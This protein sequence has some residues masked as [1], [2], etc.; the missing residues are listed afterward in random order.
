[1]T[2]PKDSDVR[3]LAG[4]LARLSNK[5]SSVYRMSWWNEKLLGWSLAHPEFKSQL[6]RLV[7]VFP[8]TS[9]N[10]D[11]MRHVEEYLGGEGVPA[12]L[13]AAIEV[14]GHVPF[15]AS[16]TAAQTRQNIARMADQFILG[17]STAEAVAGAEKLWNAG[18]GTT[19][20]L[21]GEKT[22]AESEADTYARRVTELLDALT[23][24]APTWATRPVFDA[25]DLGPLP[26][27][28]I[29]IKPT[30][31]AS[32]YKPLTGE[33]GLEQAKGRIRPIL[34]TAR[35]RNALVWFDMEHYEVKDLSIALFRQLL[36]EP[37]FAEL[38][39]GIV[40]QAYLRDSY[41]DLA[42]IVTWSA[43][44]ATPAFVR[45]VKGAYWDTETINA[46]AHD[47]PVPVFQQKP[48]SDANY[49]RCTRLLLDHH[50]EVR[51][52]F[53]SHN[54]RSLAYAISYAR[55]NGLP[56]NAF[57]IQMLYG[58]AEPMHEAIRRSGLRLR[59]YAP[60]GELV[61]GMAYLVRRL[62]E[63]TSNDSFVRLRFAEGRELDELLAVPKVDH[64]P[65]PAPPASRRPTDPVDPTPY[66]PES[67]F[68]WHRRS[69][70]EEM[71]KAVASA[72][73]GNPSYVFAVIDG[74][75]VRTLHSIDSVNPALPSKVVATSARCTAEH[76]RNAMDG[77]RAA[78][79][80]WSATPALQRATVMFRA[81][82]WMRKRRFELAALQ[83][84][85][86]GKPWADAD[87][88]VCEA[89]DFCEYY[90]REALRLSAGGAVQSP[91]GETNKLVYQPRGV[92]VVIAPWN[93]PLAIPTG[94]VVAALVTGNTVL[95]KPAEQ[96]PAIA[97]KL[98]EALHASGL[99][100]GALQFLPGVG[101]EIGPLLVEHP[102]TAFV[103][104]TGSKPVGLSIV[105]SAARHQPCQRH[106]K[107]VIAELGGK[108]PMIVDTDADLD[109]A[110]PAILY[111]AFGF[112]GQKCSALSRLIVLEGV[113]DQLVERLVGA[114][115]GMTVGDPSRMDVEVG[116]VIDA[117]AHERISRVV[118][119][120]PRWGTVRT[121][122]RSLPPVGYF[123]TPTIVA[124]VQP[125][126]PLARDEIFGPVLS[127]FRARHLDEAL[128]LANDTDYALTAGLFSRSPST[129]TRVGAEIRAGN[130]YVNRQITGA[131]VGRQPFGGYGMSGG[132]TKAGGPDYL[133][134]FVE[135][136]VVTENIVRQGF[137]DL[138]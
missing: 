35:D 21:L 11:V 104:F 47:W 50:G 124:D 38:G 83:V 137:A 26:R 101:E 59:V 132:G 45:L 14:A 116:P 102:D 16:V 71:R 115:A 3:E 87:G 43:R 4:E 107:R 29:S 51:P 31:L 20:D 6:F 95:F 33:E 23:A 88:D 32:K 24:A 77:A 56:D 96:T 75:K 69:R 10:R 99:P 61:P 28:S 86:A 74:E 54:M 7:D 63:N 73:A 57:E 52:A 112:A 103:A 60:V 134:N 135:P 128:R 48:Q 91:P 55:A 92:G 113:H 46:N 85:V 12:A 138:A 27:A 111:S 72:K 13:R 2:T 5:K 22:V 44:R 79:P 76:V 30:A 66:E 53:A 25:D 17:S 80:A 18:S 123:I 133:L 119:D 121:A 126:S 37:E 49:E 70:R 67:L 105:E 118:G 98:V 117:E 58:M 39:A 64:L 9:G 130:V 19:I 120:A 40:M 100:K 125:D 82:D 114:V 41:H 81:A 93:F 131:V 108:N 127:V 90:G 62:L 97:S 65:D 15:G 34:R 78:F 136:R 42:D 84:E 89:I 129:I 122:P 8:A 36:D 110:V 1:V 106:I 94:M 109:Q 68:E